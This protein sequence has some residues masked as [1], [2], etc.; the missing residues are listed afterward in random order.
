MSDVLEMR[1]SGYLTRRALAVAFEPLTEQLRTAESRPGLLVDCREM[2]GYEADARALFVAWFRAHQ[3]EIQR[4]AIITENTLW[5]MVVSAMSF[6]SGHEMRSF[7]E[8]ASGA[9]WLTGTPS[10]GA[11]S[12]G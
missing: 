5:H 9:E 7:A 3:G 12:K 1:L 11:R 2:T 6:A 8:P 4:T 10:D